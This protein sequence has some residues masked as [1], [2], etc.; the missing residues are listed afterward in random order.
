MPEF[1]A[2]LGVVISLSGVLTLAMTAPSLAAADR[3]HASAHHASV[4]HI[5]A[6]AHATIPHEGTGTV[7]AQTNDARTTSTI[8]AN[9]TAGGVQKDCWVE[10]DGEHGYGYQGGCSAPHGSYHTRQMQY[11]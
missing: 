10:T 9:P 2:K 7:P 6:P 1:Y 11:K 5:R 8:Q 4:H 3:E